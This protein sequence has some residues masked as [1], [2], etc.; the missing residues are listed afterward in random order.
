LTDTV[1]APSSALQQLAQDRP[2]A[3]NTAQASTGLIPHFTSVGRASQQAIRASRNSPG[4][5]LTIL[6]LRAPDRHLKMMMKENIR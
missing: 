5:P 3:S 6:Q 1:A 4:P 2:V